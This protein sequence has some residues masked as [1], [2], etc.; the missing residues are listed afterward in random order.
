M[1]TLQL[2]KIPE[3]YINLQLMLTLLIL[4]TLTANLATRQSNWSPGA[5]KTV[6]ARNTE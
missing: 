3:N 5:G 1:P 4:L 6:G 2:R